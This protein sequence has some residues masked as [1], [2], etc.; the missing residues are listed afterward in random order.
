M[1]GA[2]GDSGVRAVQDKQSKRRIGNY[3]SQEPL[4]LAHVQRQNQEA[5]RRRRTMYYKPQKPL[6]QERMNKKLIQLSTDVVFPYTSR[7]DTSVVSM[8]GADVAHKEIE[9]AE[10]SVVLQHHNAPVVG[11][12]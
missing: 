1:A 3:K 12:L 7:Q 2:A 4:W 6:Q 10:D 9:S 8:A 5:Q 11:F